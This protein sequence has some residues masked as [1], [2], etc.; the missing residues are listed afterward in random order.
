M[1]V[2]GTL[3]DGS[4]FYSSEGEAFKKFNALD[5]MG[6]MLMHS[7]NIETAFIT[8]K[9]SQ[10]AKKRAEVLNVKHIY[11]GCWEKAKALQDICLKMG[12]TAD[13]VAYI[14]DD[15]NDLD[16][17]EY[18]GFSALPANGFDSLK[19]K[20]DYICKSKGGEGAVR[21]ICEMILESRKK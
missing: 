12:I 8:S 3:T 21:E 2:D 5:G 6:I 20:V 4:L 19:S 7:N 15:I 17:L 11:I 10:I 14:G 1:D 13:E 16:A 9:D 18:A